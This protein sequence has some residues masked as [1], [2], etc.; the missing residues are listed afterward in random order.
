MS[1]D[2]KLQFNDP[3]MHILHNLPLK[4]ILQRNNE[5]MCVYKSLRHGEFDMRCLFDK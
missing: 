4:T 1:F 5:E 2:P 3:E